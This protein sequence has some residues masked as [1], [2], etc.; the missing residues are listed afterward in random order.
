MSGDEAI[1]L[2]T[3]AAFALLLW[4]AWYWRALRVRLPAQSP[5]GRTLLLIA[6]PLALATLL[7]V[8]RTS[9][10]SDVR[11]DP[12]YLLM[13]TALGS[14]WLVLG[15][16]WLPAAGISP[17]DDVLER[18]NDA[19]GIVVAAALLAVMLCYAGGNV[20][21]GP[22]WWVV[23]FSAG[24]AT[25]AFFLIWMLFEAISGVSETVTVDRDFAAAVRL[26][27][28]LF[29]CGAIFGRAAAGDWISAPATMVDFAVVARPV[30]LLLVVA[31]LVERFARPTPSR[32]APSIAAYGIAPALLYVGAAA[33][34][35]SRLGFPA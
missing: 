14:A 2:V 21:D 35:L 8:L 28:F 25:G 18:G 3:S 34:H 13:Y 33:L 10:A 5:F 12:R 4:G 29:A 32:P 1:V 24:L 17:R 31:A 11:D 15:A 16:W 9:S 19:A 30:V 7:L 20:G 22:G 6:P 23:V 27:G 26:A